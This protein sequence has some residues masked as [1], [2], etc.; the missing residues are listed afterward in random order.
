M[1][2]IPHI[3]RGTKTMSS[4]ILHVFH[5]ITV[6]TNG[7]S[8]ASTAS[9]TAD[10]VTDKTR[11]ID[12]TATATERARAATKTQWV[13]KAMVK[14]TRDGAHC[15]SRE[16]G[17]GDPISRFSFLHKDSHCADSDENN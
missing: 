13:R 14:T 16:R 5:F 7:A 15:P 9:S 4:Y 10:S 12:S 17:R 2:R 11:A 8:H 1:I 6:A 3:I